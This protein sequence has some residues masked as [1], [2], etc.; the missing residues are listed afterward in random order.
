MASVIQG[1]LGEA[2]LK[3]WEGKEG[4]KPIAG[5]LV[6]TSGLQGK[7][8]GSYLSDE[9]TEVKRRVQV[10]QEQVVK[11]GFEPTSV[12]L[13]LFYLP[14]YPQLRTPFMTL[15]KPELSQISLLTAF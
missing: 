5:H 12:S 14:S 15:Q 9:D 8:D 13:F 2:F 7:C 10:T 3:G 11:A 4:K 1:L 6:L